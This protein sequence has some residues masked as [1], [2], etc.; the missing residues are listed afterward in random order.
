MKSL[1][2]K[3]VLLSI[4]YKK[5]L[6]NT[7]SQLW[8]V[9]YFNWI[10]ESCRARA[11][12]MHKYLCSP[13]RGKFL[14]CFSKS[15]PRSGT[16]SRQLKGG[17]NFISFQ[18]GGKNTSE[19]LHGLSFSP[20]Y[21]LPPPFLSTFLSLLGFSCNRMADHS[22]FVLALARELGQMSRAHSGDDNSSALP[23]PVELCNKP[24]QKCTVVLDTF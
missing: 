20:K 17:G 23:T 6:P 13:F 21:P 15:K 8:I 1:V 3:S 4:W 22:G 14:L 16:G 2:S 11:S 9:L 24:S 5:Q 7:A 10:R 12:K 18:G 19:I